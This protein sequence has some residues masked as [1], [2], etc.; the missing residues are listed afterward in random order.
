MTTVFSA[1]TE[2]YTRPI[3]KP[4]LMC[5]LLHLIPLELSK[6][7][8]KFNHTFS[9][10]SGSVGASYNLSEKFFVKA[11]VARGF[12]APNISEISANGVHPG[13]NMYQIGNS[14]FKPEFSLQED[15]GVFFHF[16]ICNRKHRIIL[17]TIY[18]TIFLI[19]NY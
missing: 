6:V 2:M 5:R 19:K 15:F 16:K 7:F 14:G 3:L 9:G 8:S 11:N 10:I 4:D 18:Q 12:R 17:I 1:M 13:T